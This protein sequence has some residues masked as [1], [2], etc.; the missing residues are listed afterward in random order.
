[1]RVELLNYDAPNRKTYD[2]LCLL[3]VR[4]Y[5][6]VAVFAYPRSYKKAHVPLVAH[7]PD[8][9]HLVPSTEDA[10]RAFGFLH[11]AIADYDEADG[12]DAYLVCGAGLLPQGF[13]DTHRVINAHPG[14][15]PDARGLDALKWSV[16][17]GAPIG[18]TTHLLG[19]EVDA[20]EVI[21]RRLLGLR[22]GES[23]FELGMRVYCNE[24]DMLVGALVK[25]DEPHDR[26]EAGS[27][28][29]HRRMPAE[30]EAEMLEA[31]RRRQRR[32]CEHAVP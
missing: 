9:A 11:H 25:L 24:I 1:M 21:E 32:E 22:R 23:F 29:L 6:D 17:E 16:L 14:F 27:S 28:I 7:R 3:K 26:I 4:G 15:I 19:D 18:V 30:L 20:G 12:Y 10:C 2:A 31:Y 8:M 5:D 13:V